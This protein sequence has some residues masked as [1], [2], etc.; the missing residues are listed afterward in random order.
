VAARG[1]TLV[2]LLVAMAL[3]AVLAT[4]AAPGLGEYLRN[5]R[6]AATVNA[7]FHAVHAARGL[8]AVRGQ[9][10]VL[11][12]SNDGSHCANGPDW[13]RDLLLRPDGPDPA[14]GEAPPLRFIGTA[15]TGNGQSVRS[16]RDS[17]RFAALS[18]AATT[19]T[20]IVCDDRGSRAAR[21]VIVSRIGRPR[22][23]DRDA[24]GHPLACP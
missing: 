24:G 23:S 8:A 3:L 11:C 15:A 16:N 10:V 7:L 17:I 12:P 18:P 1:F 4:L 20:L 5:C 9:P 2:E 21:A 13:S 19:T 22:I 14:V 6:R